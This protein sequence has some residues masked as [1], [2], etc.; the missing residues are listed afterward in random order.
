MSGKIITIFGGS[1]FL[2]RYAVRALCKAGWRVRVAVRNPMNAGDM[3]LGGE[4]GQVQIVQA[5]VRNR[6]SVARAVEGVDAV[7]NLVGVLYERGRQSFEGSQHLGA[8]NIAELAKEAGVS[9]MIHI[10]A[11]GADADSESD[12]AQ[13]K[14]KGEAAVR[15]VYPN[16]II[17]R[18]SIL[19]GPEDGFFNKFAEFAKYLPMLPLVGGGKTQFQPVYVGD[20]ADAIVA[21]L[22]DNAAEGRTF[23]LGGPRTYS[24]KELMQFVKDQT[25]RGPLL[26]PMPFWAASLQGLTFDLFF[27]FWPFHAPP[28]TA[29][30]VRLLKVD[31]VVGATNEENVGTLADLGITELET[32]EAI[33]PTYL[34]SYRP[35]GQFQ[36]RDGEDEVSRVDL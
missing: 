12:Y 34:W 5:N 18:P 30:Q 19:F 23:E 16:A 8:R 31:N 32:I 11:I 29:D 17:L 6:P 36:I 3:R 4:V 27:K 13:T 22:T 26:L 2:G 10:S 1:G 20:V 28:L 21:S 15:E 7:L 9:Q 24:F 14:A 25:N 35:Y 33:A